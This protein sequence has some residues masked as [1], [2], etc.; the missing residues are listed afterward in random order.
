MRSTTAI[1]KLR[2]HA[3]AG[4]GGHMRSAAGL[5]DYVHHHDRHPDLEKTDDVDGLTRYVAW[6][7]HATPDARLFDAEQTLGDADRAELAAYIERSV[8]GLEQTPGWRVEHNRKAF[9]HFII[10]PEDAYGL[11]LRTATRSVLSQLEKDAGTGGLPPWIAAE[12]RNTEHPHVHVVMAARRQLA[13]GRFRRIDI[14]GPRLDQLHDAL[15]VELLKQREERAQLRSSALR[16]VEAATRSPL[17]SQGSPSSPSRTTAVQKRREIV[18]SLAWS[19]AADRDIALRREVSALPTA[20]VAR[21]A[22]RLARH[23]QRE[24]ERE[25]RRRLAEGRE[26]GRERDE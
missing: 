4:G 2:W 16:A 21:I 1:I 10:S 13:S 25:A 22:G 14:T 8:Q 9:Y 23:Y 11:D 20:Q 15:A 24:A 17:R 12:H 18:D 6:R 7:D 5:L 19:P 3:T 26:Q